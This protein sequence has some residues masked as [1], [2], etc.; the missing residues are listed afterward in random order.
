MTHIEKRDNLTVRQD[1]PAAYRQRFEV[2]FEYP[3]HFT[4][5]VFAPES[6][7]LAGVF[8][9]CDEDGPQRAMV[10]IDS[11]LAMAQPEL[12]DRIESY[13]AV[14]VDT[15]S[16]AGAVEIVPGG[17]AAKIGWGAA[18]EVVEAIAARRLD[19]HG[20]VI[21]VGGGSMLDMVG[22]ATSI[23]HRGL[24]LVRLPTTTLAQNDAGV[25]VKNGLD[26]CGVKNLVGT[27]A[28]PVAVINDFD[29][30]ATL[31][32]EHWIGGLAEAM[33]VAIIKDREFF[34]FLC[35]RGAELRSRDDVAMAEAVRR[36]A[37]LHLEHIRTSGDPFETGSARPLDFGHWIAHK[38]EAMSNFQIGHG[39]AV[40][41]G[42]A[43]D[44]Y[45]AFRTGLLSEGELDQIIAGLVGCG[46]E[47]YANLLE[48][49]TADGSLEIFGGLENFREH[50]GGRLN[51]TL[52]HSI[53]ERIEVHEIDA[54]IVAEAVTWLKARSHTLQGQGHAAG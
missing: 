52:P 26:V 25:G 47:V 14:W 3:V 34:E 9:H 6:N 10:C 44:S 4:R 1:S 39:Q 23:V 32:Q 12:V 24:R 42:I 8:G 38:L 35:S 15:M 37:M 31:P 54:T 19:R 18:R 21:T 20:Y 51:V 27:F 36:C 43:A 2:G 46:L 17:P 45:Y 28:P 33:K 30:L 13:F 41:V 5:D 48:R 29:M 50:L 49:Q 40:A 7:L 11:G 53:G 16:L 22:F